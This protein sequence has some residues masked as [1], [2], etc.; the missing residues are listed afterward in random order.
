MPESIKYAGSVSVP[1][2]PA[3]AFSETLSLEIFA[4]ANIVVSST[5]PPVVVPIAGAVLLL[6]VRATSYTGLKFRTSAT[7]AALGDLDQP[8]LIAGKG[9]LDLFSPGGLTSLTFETTNTTST[10]IDIF[11]GYQP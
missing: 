2:G 3:V 7:D 8:L 4:K 5:T 11:V 6:L 9:A 10:T 1:G